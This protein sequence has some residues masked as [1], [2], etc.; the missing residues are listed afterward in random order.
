VG[1]AQENTFQSVRLADTARFTVDLI[2]GRTRGPEGSIEDRVRAADINLLRVPHLVRSPN[3]F[4][5]WPALRELTQL[6]EVQQYDL[7]HTHTSKAGYLGRLAARRAG[8]PAIVHTPH[9]HIF[10]GYFSTLTT[11][12]YIALERH[13][14][15]FT[16]RIIALTGQEVEDHLARGIGQREQYRVVHSGI[17]MAPFEAARERREE[18]R[19]KL[20]IK[21]DEVVVGAAGR[22]ERVKGFTYLIDAVRL[23]A[24]SNPNLRLLLVGDGS[25]RTELTRA[26]A[27]L[28]RRIEFAGF[29]DDVPDLMAAFDILALP[30]LNEGMGRVLLEAGAAGTPVVATHVGGVPDVVRDGETGLLVPPKNAGALANALDALTNDAERRAHMGRAAREFVV[31]R[32]SIAS[33]V[34]ALEAIYDEVIAEKGIDAGR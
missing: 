33:M 9:G 19:R 22:L 13:A 27:P 29:R 25:L 26:A 8:V 10:G 31:P 7:V 17:D 20:G 34:R 1:G 28:G 30:S 4:C 12:F 14:A 23:L 11:R 15:Q 24:D 21:P 2:S 5:D 32:F 16:D 18:T 6:L 3:P